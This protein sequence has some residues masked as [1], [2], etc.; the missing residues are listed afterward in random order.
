MILSNEG[1]PEEK[2]TAKSGGTKSAK[3]GKG[4][5]KAREEPAREGWGEGLFSGRDA[6]GAPG[7]CPGHAVHESSLH[8]AP[9]L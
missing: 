2:S 3:Q 4:A 8:V 7:A 6:P 5:K 9:L 1:G